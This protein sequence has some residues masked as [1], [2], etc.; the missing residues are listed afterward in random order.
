MPEVWTVADDEVVATAGTDVVVLRGLAAGTEV[1]VPGVGPVRTLPR[2]GGERLA[3]ICTVNDVHFGEVECGRIQSMPEVGPVLS[4]GP[5]EAPYPEVMSRA[6]CAGIAEA[7]GRGRVPWAV[8]AKGDLTAAGT[9]P[10]YEAFLACY[11]GAFGDRLHQV[12]GNH[13]AAAGLAFAAGP[14][15]VELPGV[16]VA[17][18]D[19]VIPGDHSGWVDDG[20]LA[21]LDEV[22]R[23]A[24]V[25]GRL[26]LVL[27]HHHLWDPA[28]RARPD[29]YFGI[30]PDAS[31]RLLAVVARRPAI[32]ATAAG[33]THRNRVR[34]FAVTGGVP[35][36]EVASTKDFPGSWAEYRVHEGGMLQIHCRV[37]GSAALAWSERCRAMVGGLYAGYASGGPA[38]RCFA[39]HRR[40]VDT[41]T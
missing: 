28:S 8:V 14:R 4:V 23:Q 10:E 24:A 2:P 26:V 27:G 6:A 30:H 29:G 3:T 1:E 22:G 41:A 31:E 20:Q 36:A 32:V 19:T 35:H 39:I 9:Q 15:L 37:L 25:D 11:R 13:D 40:P 38:D 33:H 21:W 5:G 16:A 18:L 34:R 17:I 12:R 7:A